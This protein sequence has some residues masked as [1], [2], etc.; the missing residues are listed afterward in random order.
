MATIMTASEGHSMPGRQLTLDVGIP[1]RYSL[2]NF[3]AGTN[4]ELLARLEAVTTGDG[5]SDSIY[6]WGPPGSGK[7]HLLQALCRRVAGTGG[8]AAY[9]SLAEDECTPEILEG[10]A[11]AALV[12]VD[13]VDAV[14]GDR[15]WETALLALY[16]GTRGRTPVVW[17]AKQGPQGIPFALADLASR[18]RAGLVYGLRALG[19]EEKLQALQARA[20]ERGFELS[21]DAGLYVLN[22]YS[23]DMHALFALLD[24]LDRATLETQRRITIPFLQRLEQE[25]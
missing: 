4:G 10:L 25:S 11:E 9:V 6:I 7:S 18:F 21:A 5:I 19:D 3:I 8:Q 12:C 2:E 16:E 14:A 17:A 13:D 20:R 1:D 22:R 15:A 23:R 24:R